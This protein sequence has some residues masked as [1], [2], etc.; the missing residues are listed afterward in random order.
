MEKDLTYDD[1]INPGD[2]IACGDTHAR[3][4]LFELFL[5]K[6]RGTEATVILLGDILDRGGQDVEVL[7][8]VKQLL[9]DPESEGLSN[10]FCLLGNHEKLLLDA[11]NG[12]ATSLLLWLQNGGNMEQLQE[13]YEHVAWIQDLPVYMTIGETMF[14][15]AGIV[16]GRDPY[17]LVEKGNVDKLV[18]IREPFLSV[19]PKFE[20]WNPKLKQIV[21]G[22][23]PKFD[24]GEGKPYRI[25]QGVCVDSGAYFSDIL[26]AYNVTKNTFIQVTS[27]A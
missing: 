26:T 6:V 17:E 9:D 4:D 2:I 25:P 5:D 3:Y 10:F 7:N 13:I 27:N 12:P 16:P 20:E 1:K 19:G 8:K 18:W 14:C 22:H 21:F 11:Y 23:T 15:H 24:G